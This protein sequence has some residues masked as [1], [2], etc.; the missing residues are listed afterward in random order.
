MSFKQLGE[1]AII[2]GG[3]RLPQGATLQIEPNAHPY[4]RVRDMGHKHIPRDGLEYVPSDVFPKISRYIV[5]TNDVIISIVGTIGLVSIIDDYFNNASQTENC[6]K[7]TGLDKVDAEYTYYYLISSY[8]QDEIKKGT[9]GAVQAKLPLYSI[10]KINIFWPTRSI[11]EKI[12]ERLWVLDNKITLNRQINQ[13]LEAMAQALFKSWFVDFEPVKAKMAA[14]SSGGNDDDANLAAMS[15]ISGKSAQALLAMQT[16]QPEQYQQLY[17]TATLF[18]SKMVESELGEV[19]LGWEI[20]DLSTKVD[21]LNGF[22]FKSDDYVD[23]GVFVLRTKNFTNGIAH[24]YS[25]DVFLPLNFM[26]SHAKYLCE[27]FDY[28]LVMVGASVGNRGIIYPSI[29]PA[30]RNQNMWCFRPKQKNDLSKVQVKLILDNLIGSFSGLASG[31][32]REFFRK[33]DFEKKKICFG[34]AEIRS[35]F[36]K[37]LTPLLEK[38]GSLF[39]ETEILSTTRDSL[40]PKLLSG[41]LSVDGVGDD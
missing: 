36:D 14:L 5:N 38:Q 20:A 39:A 25:D 15:A 4:I 22:A 34:T 13:T 6:A 8:G 18:P 17:A 10:E 24:N 27:S 31:S 29:L 40:L 3:K 1:I 21:I 28:H 37:L 26:D 9:V 16:N 33:G 2:K 41:E 19:P 30:L 7:I 12:V 11:R 32:A 35:I 23:S